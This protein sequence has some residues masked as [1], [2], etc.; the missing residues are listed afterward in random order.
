M[1]EVNAEEKPL[2]RPKRVKAAICPAKGQFE[3]DFV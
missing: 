2:L 1:R 3:A